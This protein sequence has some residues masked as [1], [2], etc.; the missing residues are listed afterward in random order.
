M[1]YLLS[2]LLVLHGIVCLL[3]AFF[4][5]YPPV[6]L[7]YAFFPG[8]FAIRLIIVLLIGAAQVVYGGHL[9]V[10]RRWQ[11]RWHW[12]ALTVVVFTGL[13][14]I[15]PAFHGLFTQIPTATPEPPPYPSARPGPERPDDIMPTPGG[16]IYRTN[17]HQEGV[18]NPWPPI[19]TEEVVLADDVHVTYRANI[20]TKAGKGRN[21]IVYVRV[22]DKD[23]GSASIEVVNPLTGIEVKRGIQWHGPGTIAQVLVIEISQ[24]V[25]PGQYTFEIGVEI[26]GKD[27]GTI[28]CTIKVIEDTQSAVQVPPADEGRFLKPTTKILVHKSVIG[29]GQ[30]HFEGTTDTYNATLQTQLYQDEK[31]LDWW[32]A[33]QDIKANGYLWEI[34]VTLAEELP[35]E[36]Y[37]V[38]KIWVKDNPSL[39]GIDGFDLQGPP[40]MSELG[41]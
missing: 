32:P 11:V 26:D 37:Y 25:E 27:Y 5:F 4:P 20:E 24:D 18:E 29:K 39:F 35:V 8:H 2:G 34:T 15:F 17:F 31:P 6:Y 33:N 38:L 28:P 9:L 36:S 30:A 7:F 21:N 19:Q 13:L 22:P 12:L 1:V 40:S 16:P 3:G 10:K 14:L 23:I 41:K